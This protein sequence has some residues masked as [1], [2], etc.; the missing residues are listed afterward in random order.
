MNIPDLFR[1]WEHTEEYPAGTTLFSKGDPAD[2]L[3]VVLSGEV[4]LTLNGSVLS[5]EN[6]GAVIGETAMLES[7]IRNCTATTV[8]QVRLARLNRTE[9]RELSVSNSEFS[10]HVMSVLA[11]RLRIVDTYIGEKIDPD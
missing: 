2:A 8:S 3:Y 5:V 9:L 1:H 4:R 6:G 10:L 7:A 11:D